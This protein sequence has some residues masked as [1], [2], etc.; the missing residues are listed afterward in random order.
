MLKK[1]VPRKPL[2][3]LYLDHV[4]RDCRLLFEQ[5]VRIDLQVIVCKRRARRKGTEEPS[6]YWIKMKNSRYS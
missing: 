1:L 4:E 2:R 6:R 3:V 5:I